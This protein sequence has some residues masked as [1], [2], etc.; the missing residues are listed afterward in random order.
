MNGDA[1][2]FG[3]Q[4]GL[5]GSQQRHSKVAQLVLYRSHE[6][7]HFHARPRLKIASPYQLQ[8]SREK[9]KFQKQDK[10]KKQRNDETVQL[11][12]HCRK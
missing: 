1:H 10:L 3:D 11:H 9:W 8:N 4:Q 2:Q 5:C 12:L 7:A 6:L